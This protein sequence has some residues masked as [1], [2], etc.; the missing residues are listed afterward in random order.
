MIGNTLT[1]TILN[2]KQAAVVM[3][4]IWKPILMSRTKKKTGDVY[5]SDRF[6]LKFSFLLSDAKNFALSYL[7]FLE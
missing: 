1:F 5:C 3:K 6:E 7:F 2:S 4:P